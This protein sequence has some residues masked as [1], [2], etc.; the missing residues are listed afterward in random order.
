MPQPDFVLCCNN[1]CNC[2]IKWY[3]N[4]ALEL[5]IPLILID[6]P[7][8]EEESCDADRVTY[9]RAQF[10]DCIARLEAITGKK[11]DY[12]RLREVMAIS[13][14]SSRA[15]LRAVGTMANV[16]SPFSG[17]DSMPI[18]ADSGNSGRK[19]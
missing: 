1:I 7:H 14:R 16:P 19:T 3:E 2:M 17:F 13:Q 4:L 6:I 12:D 9:I 15:W 18:M 5:D 11:I 8:L 10:D